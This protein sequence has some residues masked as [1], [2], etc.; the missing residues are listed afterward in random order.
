MPS[1]RGKTVLLVDDGIAT[2]F[3]A[4]AAVVAVRAEG[5]AK[6]VLAVPVAPAASIAE[7][8]SK[9]D[10]LVCPEVPE[11]F[12]AIGDFYSDFRQ[13]TDEEVRACLSAHRDKAA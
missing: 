13:V 12:F 2:G 9:V 7:L 1:L 3:T 6:V 4:L 8:R 11:F 5:P 10:E